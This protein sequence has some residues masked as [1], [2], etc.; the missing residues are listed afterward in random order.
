MGRIA[1]L[2]LVTAAWSSAGC[3]LG[4][5]SELST[6]G[7]LGAVSFSYVDWGECGLRGCALDSPLMVGTHE[8]VRVV[9][10]P[11][12]QGAFSLLSSDPQVMAIG[13]E[14]APSCCAAGATDEQGCTPLGAGGRCAPTATEQTTVELWA[15]QPGQAVLCVVSTDGQMIDRLALDVAPP[16]A[17]ELGCAFEAGAELGSVDLGVDQA[18]GFHA[19]AFDSSGHQLKASHGFEVS[20][21][22]PAVA[23]LRAQMPLDS[24]LQ[25]YSVLDD[26]RGVI[27]ARSPGATVVA[28]R[29][30]EHDAALP[31][32][33]R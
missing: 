3:E 15:N 30:G 25:N 16:A 33:V 27:H 24:G 18:C 10:Q 5:T 23:A 22:D 6:P 31:V 14:L 9:A 11:S 28:A 13:T 8:L 20:V 32:S 19:R 29:V 26:A 12:A 21:A 4:F 1:C 7:E 2:L 17:V